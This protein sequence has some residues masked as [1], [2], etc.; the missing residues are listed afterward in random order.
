MLLV[1]TTRFALS[2]AVAKTGNKIAARIA[3]I[4]MTTSNSISVKARR[5]SF[6]DTEIRLSRRPL[7]QECSGFSIIF[8]VKFSCFALAVSLVG[9]IGCGGDKSSTPNAGT[10]AEGHTHVEPESLDAI[11]AKA[12]ELGMSTTI[13][14]FQA[15]RAD[16]IDEAGPIYLK[17]TSLMDSADMDL[18]DRYLKGQATEAEADKAISGLADEFSLIE[19]AVSKS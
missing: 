1:Q 3:M 12:K 4:A 2:F 6:I 19:S 9:L 8:I 7:L 16:R 11:L 17:L 15:A 14:E 10:A 13:E 5:V 18:L